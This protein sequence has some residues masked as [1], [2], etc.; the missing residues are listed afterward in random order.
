MNELERRYRA[1]LRAYPHSWRA[2][3]GD[4]MVATYLDTAPAGRTIPS[5]MDIADVVRGSLRHRLAATDAGLAV[6]GSRIAAELALF[7]A[8]ALAAVWFCVIELAAM[9]DDYILDELGPV[10]SLGALAWA[11]W[12]AVALA[13]TVLKGRPMRIAVGIAL[14]LTALTIPA[15]AVVPFFR[16]SLTVL[17]PQLALGAVALF[18]SPR[19]RLRARYGIAVAV[20]AIAAIA[21]SARPWEDALT[22]RLGFGDDYVLGA[23]GVLLGTGAVAV[24]VARAFRR[25][26]DG[27]WALL[28]VLTPV[29]LLLMPLIGRVLD[30]PGLAE[31]WIGVLIIAVAAAVATVSLLSVVVRLGLRRRERARA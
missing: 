11:S 23:A 7:G 22:Y 24:A 13:G 14:G 26:A 12:I 5:I 15:P 20:L 8:A 6:R 10:Q 31:S 2:E 25:S 9:P 29:M 21:L 18:L 19:R 4:E 3:R 16:P 1:V 17:V 30:A 28:I 27:L